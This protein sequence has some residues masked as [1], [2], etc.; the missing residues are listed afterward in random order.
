MTVRVLIVDDEEPFRTAARLVVE[1]TDGFEVVGEADAGEIVASASTVA[2]AGGIAAVPVGLRQVRSRREP[3][4]VN[5][6]GGTQ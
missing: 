5:R 4:K 1:S 6:M 2:A 3:V